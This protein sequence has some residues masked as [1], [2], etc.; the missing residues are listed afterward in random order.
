MI[1]L[2]AGLTLRRNVITDTAVDHIVGL[3]PADEAAWAP[4][5]GQVEEFVSKRCTLIPV[6]ADVQR[7]LAA[8]GLAVPHDYGESPGEVSPGEVTRAPAA[9]T[10][11][12]AA[13]QQA[14]AEGGG[15]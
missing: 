1:S 15:V 5:I 14:L 11:T 10:P 12:T 2:A 6:D 8:R 9:A 7:S 3:V 13:Y 4:C